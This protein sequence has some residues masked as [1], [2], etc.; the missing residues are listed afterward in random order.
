M[1]VLDT[2][3]LVSLLKGDPRAIDSF[4]IL[5]EEGSQLSTTTITAYELLKGASISSRPD[6]NL[7]KVRDSLSNLRVLDLSW[8]ACEEASRIYK[9]LRE[10][11]KVIGEFD[12]LIAAVTRFNDEYLLTHDEDFRAIRGMKIVMW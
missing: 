11:G 6:A 2:S 7:R 5:E 3:V 1:P 9:E 8:G 12:I 10:K 4:K